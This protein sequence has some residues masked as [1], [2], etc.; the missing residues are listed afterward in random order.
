MRGDERSERSERGED[1][2]LEEKNGTQNKTGH[3]ARRDTTKEK[4]R[5]TVKTRWDTTICHHFI[6]RYSEKCLSLQKEGWRMNNKEKC[7]VALLEIAF[8]ERKATTATPLLPI[9]II[10]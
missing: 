4:R 9:S 1:K 10:R 7:P 5:K 8:P 2:I 6:W 3:K